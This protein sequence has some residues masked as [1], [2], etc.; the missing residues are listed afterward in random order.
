MKIKDYLELLPANISTNYISSPSTKG[1]FGKELRM[2][3]M[4]FINFD[5][6]KKHTVEIIDKIDTSK[7][8]INYNIDE[9]TESSNVSFKNESDQDLITIRGFKDFKFKEKIKLYALFLQDGEVMIRCTADSI[10]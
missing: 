3:E 10:F 8:S 5:E 9:I 6:F 2:I 7:L 1:L 4:Y